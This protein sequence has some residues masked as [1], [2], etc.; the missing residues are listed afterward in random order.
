MTASVGGRTDSLPCRLGE[1]DPEVLDSPAESLER[2]G[3]LRAVA[4]PRRLLERLSPEEL[5]IPDIRSSADIALLEKI[6]AATPFLG[7][8]TGWGAEFGRELNVSDDRRHFDGALGGLPVLEGKHVGPFQVRSPADVRRLPVAAAARLLDEAR[9][10]GRPRLAY[11]DVAS[12][13]NRLTLIAAVIPRGHVTVHTLFCLKTPIPLRDQEFLCGVLNSFVANYLVRLR[14]TTHVTAR[15][16]AR[17]PVPRPPVNSAAYTAVADLAARLLRSPSPQ[18]DPAYPELQA[19]VAHLYDLTS[20][21]L[22]HIL[23]TFPLI[24]ARTKA[25]TM[26]RFESCDPSTRATG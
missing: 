7:S 13:T 16:M 3:E 10:W 5:A 15:I 17:V 1:R 18:Q 2:W 25:L 20:E 4:L 6:A 19:A 8:P 23:S 12:A 14:V 11:R 21:E 26:T 9:T 24:D 22:R